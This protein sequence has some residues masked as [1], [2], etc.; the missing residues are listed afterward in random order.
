M[1]LV[2]TD[3]NDHRLITRFKD[4]SAEAMEKIVERYQESIFNFGLRMCGHMQDAK[5]ILQDTFLNA[6]S[7]LHAF[8]EET[9]LKNL[10]FRIAAY[11]CLR[12][13][14]KKKFQP[15]RELSL[16]SFMPKEGAE[17]KFEIPDLS[18]NPAQDLMR[19]ELKQVIEE[20]VYSLPSKYKFDL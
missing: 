13:R 8:R 1:A 6:F 11:A 7:G 9:K 5:D 17:V 10:L 3:D 15:D 19:S 12:K 2:K 20:A 4:G 18:S 14:R 16:E